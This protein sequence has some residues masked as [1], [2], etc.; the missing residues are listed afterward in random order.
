MTRKSGS[1]MTVGIRGWNGS[2]MTLNG[3]GDAKERRQPGT[4][5]SGFP[6][7][8]KIFEV[9][10]TPWKKV[11]H[12]V[13]KFGWNSRR[14]AVVEQGFFRIGDVDRPMDGSRSMLGGPLGR[15]SA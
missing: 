8:G 5:L 11:F 3:T 6:R 12:T 2:A 9:F 15:R 14:V 7:Y 10:S 13:E 4:G 1:A